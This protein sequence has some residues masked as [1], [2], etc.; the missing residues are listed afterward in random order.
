MSIE[1]IMLC[2][3]GPAILFCLGMALYHNHMGTRPI[4]DEG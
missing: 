2:I 3:F 1:L 4:S